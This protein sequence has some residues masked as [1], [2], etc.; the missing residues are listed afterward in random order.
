MGSC[1]GPTRIRGGRDRRRPCSPRRS[2]P[3]GPT[4][5]RRHGRA[6]APTRT[7]GGRAWTRCGRSIA[8]CGS[9]STSQPAAGSSPRSGA[10]GRSTGRGSRRASPA[11]SPRGWTQGRSRSAPRGFGPSCRL[12]PAC[13]SRPDA[14]TWTAGHVLLATGPAELPS[15]NPILASLV[16]AGV[17]RPGSMDL[18]IDVDVA[19]YRL[20][21]ADGGSAR[22]V[23]A[24]GPTHPGRGLGDD[25]RARDPRRGGLDRDRHPRPGLTPP[26]ATS[27]VGHPVGRLGSA[28]RAV[29]GKAARRAAPPTPRAVRL[30]P[31]WRAIRPRS[32]SS[33]RAS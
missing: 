32:S 2:S 24:L 26:R 8:T 7:A 33:T 27:P 29:P 10:T 28:G 14:G 19:T 1:R 25:R 12:P 13:G 17:G 9:H 4:R 22:P 6:S 5:S 23:Y 31:T 30:E 20:L 18:G 3:R 11:T 21:D 16:A 15:A